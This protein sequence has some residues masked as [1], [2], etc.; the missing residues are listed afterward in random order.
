MKSRSARTDA[1]IVLITLLFEDVGIIYPIIIDTRCF[2]SS[3]YC[4]VGDSEDA[5]DGACNMNGRR[6][7]VVGKVVARTSAEV[8]VETT[9]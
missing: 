8:T 7:D 2:R 4:V 6:A 5:E 3:L 1:D 9:T